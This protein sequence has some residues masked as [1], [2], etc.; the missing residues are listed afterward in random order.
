MSLGLKGLLNLVWYKRPSRSQAHDV[1]RVTSCCNK[2]PLSTV[3]ILLQCSSALQEKIHV[4][5]FVLSF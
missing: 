5:D 4:K 1:L 2:F 3:Y